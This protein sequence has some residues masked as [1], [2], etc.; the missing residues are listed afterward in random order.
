MDIVRQYGK[1]IEKTSET[2]PEKALKAVIF[3]LTLELQKLKY[4]PDPRLP[5]AMQKQNE[6]STCCVLNNLKHPENTVWSNIFAPVELFQAFDL[7]ALSMECMSSY[8]SGFLMEDYYIDRAESAGIA[9]TLCS[10]HKNFIGAAE[11]G[12]IPSPLAAV[13]TTAFCDGNLSSF[14]YL[15]QTGIIEDLFVLDIPFQT[16]AQAEEYICSQMT[17]LVRFLERKTGKTLDTGK[18]TEILDRE[19]ESKRHYDSFLKKRRTHAYPNTPGMMLFMLFASH[20]YIGSQWVLDFYR[21]MDEEIDTYPS[22]DPREKQLLWMHIAPYSEPALNRLLSYDT[23]YAIT[24]DDFNLDF[25][26]M[27]DTSHPLQAL[28]HKIAANIYNG[29]FERKKKACLQYV[30]K[31]ECDGAVQFCHWGCKQSSGSTYLMKQAMKQEGI[32]MLILDSDALDR[33]NMQDSQIATRME[34]F[35]EQ[36]Q[37]GDT[38]L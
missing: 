7:N 4:R 25:M 33:R 37:K 28:S 17:E 22:A 9:D 21:Q 8:L 26:E 23:G 13:T 10:Y 12:M 31:Y 20:M 5:K 11:T 30:K 29:P 35:E 14:R 24:A 6:Q 34:A 36:L 27:L 16:D 3:G 15:K 32:P 2:D 18:L 19:N 38:G 1:W